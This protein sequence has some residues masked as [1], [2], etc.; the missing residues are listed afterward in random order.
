LPQTPP[1]FEKIGQNFKG[2]LVGNFCTK[3]FLN[4]IDN[5]KE[6]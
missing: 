3:I 1:T 6:L 5:K 2:I 4:G